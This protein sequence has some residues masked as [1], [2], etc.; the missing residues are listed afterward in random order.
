MEHRAAGRAYRML[1]SDTFR[2][3]LTP[4]KTVILILLIAAPIF[5]AETKPEVHKLTGD[6]KAAIY[7]SLLE[8]SQAQQA[9]SAA[10][11]RLQAALNVCPH[12][13]R[14]DDKTGDI[15]CAPKPA[16][17]AAK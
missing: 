4:M 14:Q 12:G 15:D 9:L 3:V 16:E 2:G 1:Y 10:Q 5:A 8:Q 7:K 17:P 6:E 11:Q 13:V